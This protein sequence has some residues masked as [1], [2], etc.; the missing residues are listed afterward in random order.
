[1]LPIVT[2]MSLLSSNWDYI[3]R[4]S[5]SLKC[6]KICLS[7]I[8]IIFP[9]TFRLYV[10]LMFWYD[11]ISCCANMFIGLCF[12]PQELNLL[13]SSSFKM[14]MSFRSFMMGSNQ[15]H[16][17]SKSV[18]AN[19]YLN[20]AKVT[21][22]WWCGNMTHSSGY[23]GITAWVASFVCEFVPKPQQA[24]K[25]GHLSADFVGL[26]IDI[27]QP[28]FG[29]NFDCFLQGLYLNQKKVVIGQSCLYCETLLISLLMFVCGYHFFCQI[30]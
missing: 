18:K 22:K 7:W 5:N 24:S 10:N 16:E 8:P 6:S 20:S 29:L 30:S 13:R 25:E 3:L 15:F 26:Y 4:K 21:S 11:W 14:T 27:N 1:M 9:N 2:F 17:M 23:V 28:G 12:W 19:M